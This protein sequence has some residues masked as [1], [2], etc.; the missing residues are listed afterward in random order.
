MKYNE[1]FIRN[2]EIQ[3]SSPYI[4]EFFLKDLM[5]HISTSQIYLICLQFNIVIQ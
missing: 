3:Y 1:Q 4:I 5:A 2:N